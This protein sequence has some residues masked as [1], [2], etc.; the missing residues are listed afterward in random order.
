MCQLLNLQRPLLIFAIVKIHSLVQVFNILC[1]QNVR[2][3]FDD[4]ESSR[5]PI[6]ISIAI[7][8]HND[9]HCDKL[10]EVIG[11]KSNLKILFGYNQIKL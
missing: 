7:V 2:K 4:A 9:S 6:K 5:F 11:A 10:S 3:I 8:I 1:C